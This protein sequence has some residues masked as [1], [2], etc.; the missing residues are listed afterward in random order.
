MVGTRARPTGGLDSITGSA[1][2]WPSSKRLA[3]PWGQDQAV[4]SELD[5]SWV[6]E[7]CQTSGPSV[8]REVTCSALVTTTPASLRQC[9]G[10]ECWAGTQLSGDSLPL[11]LPLPLTRSFVSLRSQ[12]KQ[13]KQ[14]YDLERVLDSPAKGKQ[15]G[16]SEW[17]SHDSCWHPSNQTPTASDVLPVFGGRYFF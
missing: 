8:C 4:P 14:R 9:L 15:R 5:G 17:C 10:Q 2:T 12:S 3:H 7:V 13:T 6:Q 11:P 16:A 1:R